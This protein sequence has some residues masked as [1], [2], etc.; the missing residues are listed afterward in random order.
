[1]WKV[2][3][4]KKVITP[5]FAEFWLNVNY[6]LAEEIQRNTCMGPHK[7]FIFSLFLTIS[8]PLNIFKLTAALIFNR[9]PLSVFTFIACMYVHNTMVVSAQALQT[10]FFWRKWVFSESRGWFKVLVVC[11]IVTCI[12]THLSVAV[13][14]VEVG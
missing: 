13:F 9:V 12:H 4:L 11:N 3:C 2:P 5:W 8:L 1:M 6:C 7:Q 14:Y 10:T